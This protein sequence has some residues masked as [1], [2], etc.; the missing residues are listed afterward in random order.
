MLNRILIEEAISQIEKIDL[1]KISII[2]LVKILNPLFTGFKVNV[3]IYKPDE[4]IFLG[5]E[6]V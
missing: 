5:V 4:V 1:E 3:P 6:F 2:E